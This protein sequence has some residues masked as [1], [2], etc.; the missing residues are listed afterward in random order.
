MLIVT[1][2]TLSSKLRRSGMGAL[3]TRARPGSVSA[4]SRFIP[5]LWR[6][7]SQRDSAS[8]PRVARNELPW[9]SVVRMLPTPT[10]LCPRS[11][12]RQ[13]T[14]PLGLMRFYGRKPRVA[15]ASQ[16]RTGGPNPLG[17]GNL[18]GCVRP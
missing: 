2:S 18:G 1:H 15:R 12:Q 11:S 9:E 8:K 17:I 16:S 5:F 13:A 3:L 7:E 14:T 6:G 4:N 10:G